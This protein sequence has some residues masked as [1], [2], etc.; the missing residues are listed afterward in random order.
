MIFLTDTEIE[1]LTGQKQRAAQVRALRRMSV[2]HEVNPV[3]EL[4]V[5]RQYI[6][7][8]LGGLDD[9]PDTASVPN[10]GWLHGKAK[11]HTKPGVLA[12]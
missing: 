7:R 9:L 1:M 2:P 11:R 3:G 12:S 6:E 5:S 10:F 8:R 4:L